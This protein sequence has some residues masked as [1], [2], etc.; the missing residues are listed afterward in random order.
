[1]RFKSRKSAATCEY[2]S[3]SGCI[4]RNLGEGVVKY[5]H[6]GES[7]WKENQILQSFGRNACYFIRGLER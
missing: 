3:G 6:D 2:T 4:A 1:M 7:R 5:V